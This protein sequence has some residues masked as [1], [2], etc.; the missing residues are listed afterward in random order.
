MSTH[1]DEM[2]QRNLGFV[3]HDEQLRLKEAHVFVPGV[4]GMG[5]VV[6]ASLVRA[7]VGHIT[8]TD[9]DHFE[10]SNLNRQIFADAE[11]MGAPKAEVTRER[12]L[13]INPECTVETLGSDWVEHLD[14]LLPSVDVV[15]NG[16]DDVR[17]TIAL[18]RAAARHGVTVVD[19]CASTLPNVLVVNPDDARPEKLLGYPTDGKPFAEITEDDLEHCRRCEMK[20]VL[21]QT[22]T[23]EFVEM[24]IAGEVL[25]G[26]RPRISF[27][28]M[29][30]M[31]GCLMGYEA[32]RS[33]L[34]RPRGPG[35]LGWFVN[36]W[37][38]EVERPRARVRR[39]RRALGR[40]RLGL[41]AVLCAT[42]GFSAACSSRIEAPS[43][44]MPAYE[45][46]QD[47]GFYRMLF[48]D[49]RSLSDETLERSAVAWKVAASALV[50]HQHPEI[51]NP[52]EADFAAL[53]ERRF[54]FVRPSRIANWPSSEPQPTWNRPVGL[55]S[56][57]MRVG[58]VDFELEVVNNGCATC[59]STNLYDAEGRPT[60]E[61]WVG[62]P[63]G[64]V[65]FGRYADEL[66][67]ALLHA[68]TQPDQ[69]LDDV[70]SM[71]PDVSADELQT[72]RGRY[73]PALAARLPELQRNLGGFTPYSN[74]SPGLMNGVATLKLYLG[75]LDPE[76]PA[77]HE[78]AFASVPDF[79]GLRLKSSLL[80]DGVYAPKGWAHEGPRREIG[81][82]EHIE[83]LADVLTLVTVGTLG[84]T[85]EVA[86][87]NVPEI[88]DVLDWVVQRYEPPPF[89]GEVDVARVERGMR[90]FERRCAHCHG[91]YEPVRGEAGVVARY[92][93]LDFP[94]RIVRSMGT[95]P[96]RWEAA[97]PEYLAMLEETPVG[98]AID[99]AQTGGYVA[100]PLT[101]LWVSAPYLHNGSVPTL[102]ALAGLELRPPRFEVGGHPLDYRRMGLDV[103]DRGDGVARYPDGYDP[104]SEPT[105]RDTTRPGFSNRGHESPFEGLNEEERW[106][107]V[108]VMKLL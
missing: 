17:A 19:A 26:E 91:H 57:T 48:E 85:P 65:N 60:R 11:S 31:T 68:S 49:F 88:Q 47:V 6:V 94:N 43:A 101:G 51:E 83:V 20:F 72:L 13:G 86:V 54:G 71:F 59:H 7:G 66:F 100:P 93:L 98:R 95:E 40:I 27:A 82:E 25:R 92:R 23:A 90:V 32:I 61:V 29:V 53:L 35:P 70:R 15:V 78:V 14:R 73:L 105:V 104:W 1:Y 28:P 74:G 52:S 75:A 87:D 41:A 106:A 39:V 38:G 10:T 108:E 44:A 46:Q 24:E 9:P 80:A 34:G 2:V 64:S 4:G 81:H 36:P 16:C 97:R 8:L 42:V 22:R 99:T 107:L 84:V 103:T 69:V 79:F 55:V 21:E 12:L 62:A 102:A 18:M 37:T 56:G 76:R 67:A 89:P 33:I 30:W 50:R 63:A 96:F 77:P 45:A 5:G 58:L 3:S